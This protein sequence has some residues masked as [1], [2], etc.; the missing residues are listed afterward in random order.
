MRS[1]ETG[2][3]GFRVAG[4]RWRRIIDQDLDA[5]VPSHEEIG[6]QDITCAKI[7]GYDRKIHE[8]CVTSSWYQ[9]KWNQLATRSV[10]HALLIYPRA[11]VVMF[12][13]A[14]RR[15]PSCQVSHFRNQAPKEQAMLFGRAAVRIG[16]KRLKRRRRARRR[17]PEALMQLRGT[18]SKAN[19]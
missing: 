7:A 9:R 8:F 19:R 17:C 11:E 4:Y 14:A 18:H 10:N 15:R 12:V 16:K 13:T 5:L 2:P 6:E 1:P 3:S